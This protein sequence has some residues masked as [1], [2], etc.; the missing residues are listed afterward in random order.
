MTT[1]E[2][3]KRSDTC[4]IITVGQDTY[5][6]STIMR[7]SSAM[8]YSEPYAESLLFEYI[9][10]STKT[11][12]EFGRIK[13]SFSATELLYGHKRALDKIIASYDNGTFLDFFGR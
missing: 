13:C 9:Y 5:I 8:E 6:L 3:V 10:D 7:E 12:G 1:F 2:V 11:K 4:H